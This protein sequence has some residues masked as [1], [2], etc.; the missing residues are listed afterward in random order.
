M[1]C[2]IEIDLDKDT[3]VINQKTQ[4]ISWSGAEFKSWLRRNYFT[5]SSFLKAPW[6]KFIFRVKILKTLFSLI[7]WPSKFGKGI[8]LQPLLNEC[9]EENLKFHCAIGAYCNDTNL[10]QFS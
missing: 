4:F 6:F 10:V 8:F 9:Y 5:V 2:F 1:F 3:Q 7:L